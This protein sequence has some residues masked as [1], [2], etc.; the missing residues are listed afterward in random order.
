M[1]SSRASSCSSSP[2]IDW[3]LTPP[4]CFERSPSQ[5][6][7]SSSSAESS[8]KLGTDL[9]ISV[10]EN[11]L[12]EHPSVSVYYRYPRRTI[13]SQLSV[14]SSSY[15]DA[16]VE[17]SKENDDDTVEEEEEVGSITSSNT[18]VC[19]RGK[20]ITGKNP[21]YCLWDTNKSAGNVSLSLIEQ[22]RSAS[23]ENNRKLSANR[24]RRQN[25]LIRHQTLKK[26]ATKKLRQLP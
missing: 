17:E 15:F 26:C 14:K 22:Q 10:F 12:I 4:S 16:D 9:E 1:P 11:L 25:S 8:S 24:L 21:A 6:H 18:I 7:T 20:S 3:N 5:S 2:L 23:I 19:Q 13:A